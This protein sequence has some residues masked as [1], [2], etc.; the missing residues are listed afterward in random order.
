MSAAEKVFAIVLNCDEICDV[1]KYWERVAFVAKYD[2]ADGVLE[3]CDV[4]RGVQEFHEL[5][6]QSEDLDDPLQQS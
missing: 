2:K 3:I 4:S 1:R 6:Q 5:L